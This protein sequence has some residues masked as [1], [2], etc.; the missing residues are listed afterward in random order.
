MDK[1]NRVGRLKKKDYI[2][3]AVLILIVVIM[4]LLWNY[5]FSKNGNKCVVMY[6]NQTIWSGTLDEDILLVIQNNN[7]RVADVIDLENVGNG[8]T[9]ILVIEDGRANM[10]WADC[11]DKI[12]VNMKAISNMGES[13]VCMPEKIVVT[14][15]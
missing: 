9:N 5:M 15:E 6:S 4:I 12:C 2:I 8:V 10:I 13:I 1:D 3:L 7:V 11:P 14:I